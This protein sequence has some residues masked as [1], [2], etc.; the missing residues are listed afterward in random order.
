MMAD[1]N[2]RQ[3]QKVKC[4]YCEVYTTKRGRSR[5]VRHAHP[6]V[7]QQTSASQD[8]ISGNEIRVCG[9][10]NSFADITNLLTLAKKN[11]PVLNAIPKSSRATLNKIFGDVLEEALSS[12]NIEPWIKLFTF[13][14]ITLR[15]R[16]REF[17]KSQGATKVAKIY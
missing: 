17:K 11:I 3:S 5:H 15:D 14:F 8:S 4:D 10:Q 12:D 16:P 7:F 9:D 2:Q 13:A 6:S 1:S